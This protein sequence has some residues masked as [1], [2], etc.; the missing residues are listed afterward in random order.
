MSALLAAGGGAAALVIILIFWLVLVRRRLERGWTGVRDC[1]DALDTCFRRRAELTPRLIEIAR[2]SL[3]G[4]GETLASLR[5][6]RARSLEGRNPVERSKAED[7]ISLAITRIFSAGDDSPSL[8]GRTDFE[9]LKERLI[10]AGHAIVHAQEAYREAARAYN[11]MADTFPASFM[12]SDS[13]AVEA[14]GYN[15]GR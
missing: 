10:E 12:G 5:R 4:E 13:R 6:L 2:G 14:A 1:A 15:T 8:S 3:P 9:W 11:K 7:A